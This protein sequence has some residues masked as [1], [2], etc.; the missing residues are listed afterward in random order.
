LSIRFA[1]TSAL[2]ICVT[3][4]SSGAVALLPSVA[5]AKPPASKA[6]KQPIGV[7]AVTGPQGPKIR[8]KLL[9]LL[10]ASGTYEVTDVEDVKPGASAATYQS[11][12]QGTGSDAIIV[13]NVSKALNLTLSVYGTNG[14][15]LGQITVKGGTFPKLFKAV[16]NE[17]EIA[18]ADPLERARQGG[19]AAAAPATKPPLAP[20]EAEEDEEIEIQETPKPK[21]KAKPEP[22][23]KD[24]PKVDAGADELESED[25]DTT[26]GEP[27]EAEDDGDAE[28]EAPAEPATR[29]RRPLELYAGMRFFNRK[30]AYTGRTTPNLFPYSMDLAPAIIVGGRVYPGALLGDGVI[31]HVGIMG[32]IEFGLAPPTNYQEGGQNGTPK[33]VV[34]LKT[35]SLEYELGLR[36]RLPIGAH[37]LGVFATFG[38]QNFILSGDEDPLKV[39]YA[40]VP[41]VHYHY[42]RIGIDARVYISKLIAGAHLAPRFLTSMK[43]LDKGLT[44]FPGAKGSGLDFGMMLG[45]QLLP[46]LAPAAGFDLIRY[47]FDF[48]NLPV[49][50]KPRAVAGGATDTYMSGWL[51]VLATFDFAG[52]TSGSGA[53]VSAVPAESKEDEAASSKEDEAEEEEEEEAPPKKAAPAKAKKPAADDEEEEAEEEQADE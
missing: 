29:G 31:S 8:A 38:N 4:A 37:E 17:V 25:V 15:R 50:P 12:A 20:G 10:R 1:A 33:V 47:G 22:K 11:M 49:D 26:T 53:S 21:P 5:H 42:F 35:K 23:G 30:F 6:A 45:W 51:G 32:R 46:W 9:K 40:L 34:P 24:K 28:P 39:P 7:G 48:N 3:L 43:E 19:G 18:I 36:G 2:A 41:D 27:I 14:A 13:G 16:E 52:G 44:W